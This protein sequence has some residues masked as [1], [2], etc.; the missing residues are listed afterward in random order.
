MEGKGK[1]KGLEARMLSAAK[2]GW[3]G[4]PVWAT[5]EEVD[6]VHKKHP[7]VFGKAQ[8][9]QEEK[10]KPFP[11]LRLESG[12]STV[13]LPVE[14]QQ[15]RLSTDAP[16]KTTVDATVTGQLNAPCDDSE[17][18]DQVLQQGVSTVAA[19]REHG[20]RKWK[21]ERY[22]CRQGIINDILMRLSLP[23]PSVDMFSDEQNARFEKRCG[24]GAD[25]EDA[26]QVD[27][28]RQGLMW[29]NPPYSQ[30]QK[31]VNK[32]IVDRGVGIMLLPDWRSCQWW[33]DIQPYVVK[34]HWYAPGV[35]VFEV[36]GTDFSEGT[37]WPVWAYYVDCRKV[38]SKEKDE[39]MEPDKEYDGDV[40]DGKMQ[41]TK[42]RRRRQQR[43]A[44]QKYWKQQ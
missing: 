10:L 24:P 5:Q 17:A 15:L 13:G 23:K 22:A 30:L 26:F 27:W 37:K 6:A 38:H 44:A 9:R 35:K 36:A 33:T 32:M 11:T 42:A 43:R 14:V 39:W 12:S 1:G 41:N 20:E 18:E 25:I 31:T 29:M 21:T 34:R 19:V 3:S 16:A 28:G 4:I 2:Q 8:G 40:L 7:D